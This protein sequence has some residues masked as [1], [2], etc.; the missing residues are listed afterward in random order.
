M[1]FVGR[2]E[3]DRPAVVALRPQPFG[4]H[5]RRA[6][7]RPAIQPVLPVQP[8]RAPEG[9]VGRDPVHLVEARVVEVVRIDRI[10]EAAQRARADGQP[11]QHAAERIDADERNR[12]IDLAQR[13]DRAARRRAGADR[14]DDREIRAE[15]ADQLRGERAVRVLI[16]RIVVLPR[17]E[18]AGVL[19]QPLLQ[20]FEP[21]HLDVGAGRV[22]PD[23]LHAPAQ[24]PQA[25][26]QPFVDRRVADD[27]KRNALFRAD[28]P[29]AHRERAARRLEHRHPG[30][31]LPARDRVLDDVLR[32]HELHQPERRRDEPRREPDQVRMVERAGYAVVHRDGGPV[33]CLGH[34]VVHAIDCSSIHK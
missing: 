10:A 19:A 17:P 28:D 14:A 34:D 8:A 2:D 29:D 11:E 13:P 22:R 3:H 24:L 32:G 30:I 20:R 21:Q 9:F 12:R 31:Q 16:V 26:L 1:P 27:V 18:A 25:R 4:D 5:E 33:E 6:G 23:D 7:R 15:R